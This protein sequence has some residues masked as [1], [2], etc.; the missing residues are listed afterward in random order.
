MIRVIRPFHL[1][2]LAQV[3]NEVTLEVEGPATRRS[4]LDAR[5]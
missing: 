3:G 5:R 1:R 4:V 2:N